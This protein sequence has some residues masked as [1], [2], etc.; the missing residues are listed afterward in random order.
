ML[1]RFVVEQAPAARAAALVAFA[2]QTRCAQLDPPDR[3]HAAAAR[4]SSLAVLAAAA[5][6]ST[7]A[8]SSAMS[9]ATFPLTSVRDGGGSGSGGGA[10]SGHS[11]AQLAREAMERAKQL[12]AQLNGV[13]AVLNVKVGDVLAKQEREFLRAYRA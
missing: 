5:S 2:K 13:V 7:R 1:N 11:G 6:T 12:H 3:S 9:D 8:F 4:L 10:T